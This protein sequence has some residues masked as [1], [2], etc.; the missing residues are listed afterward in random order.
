MNNEDI[1]KETPWGTVEPFTDNSIP[2]CARCSIKLTKYNKSA[3][4]DVI[5]NTNKIQGICKNCLTLEEREAENSYGEDTINKDLL[6]ER[7]AQITAHRVCLGSEHNPFKGK[8][9]GYCVVCGVPF[10]CD[11]VGKPPKIE[12]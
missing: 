3:W 10:P 7:I 5:K 11:Y 8:L 4:S 6:L 1:G 2:I 9:H 12:K